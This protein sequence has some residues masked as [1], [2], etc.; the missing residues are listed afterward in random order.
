M[1][2]Y[3][4]QLSAFSMLL[5]KLSAYVKNAV[6]LV[7]GCSHPDGEP[8]EDCPGVLRLRVNAFSRIVCLTF[9]Q[10]CCVSQPGFLY[11]N[12]SGNGIPRSGML[13]Q[14]S[15]LMPQ[16]CG[17]LRR[18]CVC[19]GDAR[20]HTWCFVSWRRL[21]EVLKYWVR[22]KTWVYSDMALM[23]GMSPLKLF[24]FTIIRLSE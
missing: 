11:V 22:A 3:V 12:P 6:F 10:L 5:M 23:F 16:L 4:K 24:R 21:F 19:G 7:P 13:S 20:T 9:E 1:C 17:L 15:V 14:L 18:V 8:A 2:S